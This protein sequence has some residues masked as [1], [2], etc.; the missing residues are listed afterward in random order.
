MEIVDPGISG[1]DTPLYQFGKIVN[2]NRVDR[3]NNDLKRIN[4][5]NS[6]QQTALILYHSNTG[7][8]AGLAAQAE[9]TLK[10]SGWNVRKGFFEN[11]PE[12]L[13]KQTPDLLLVGT[14]VH[15]WQIPVPVVKMIRQLPRFESIPAFIFLTYG[16][17]FDGNAPYMLAEEISKLGASVIGGAS[18]IAPHGFMTRQ[19]TRLGDTLPEF[20][21]GQP[22]Q[23]VLNRFNHAVKDAAKK[24]EEGINSFDIKQMRS[25]KPVSTFL[26]GLLPVDLQRRAMPKVKWDSEPCTKC[27]KCIN[28]CTTG[29]ISLVKNCIVTDHSTCSRCYQCLWICESEARSADLAPMAGLLKQLK[30]VIK[31]PGSR[32]FK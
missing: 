25:P 2:H 4:M 24:T 20:G 22:D 32:I 23:D 30:K 15:F 16:A 8:T 12:L 11:A 13:S 21:K 27:Q 17:V 18:V 28:G 7:N 14:P 1:P 5:T 6:I 19:R 29:S 10:I 31:N 26:G 9:Q 3:I